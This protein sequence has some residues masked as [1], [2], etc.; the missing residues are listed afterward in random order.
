MGQPSASQPKWPLWLLG[1]T[2][3]LLFALALGY[4]TNPELLS[5]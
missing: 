2:L 1:A 4:W 5:L 3:L